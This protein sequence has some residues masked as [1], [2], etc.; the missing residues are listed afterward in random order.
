MPRRAARPPCPERTATIAP[1]APRFL[2][3]LPLWTVVAPVLAGLALLLGKPASPALA[4]LDA[5]LLGAAVLAA[6]H[7]A[8]TVAHAVGEPFGSLVLALAVT[9]IETSLIVSI[10]LTEGAA[11]APLARDTLFATVMIVMNG[12]VGLCLLVGGGRHHEQG[13]TRSGV[14]AGLAMLSTLAVLVLVLPNYTVTRAGPVYAPTQLV[15]VGVVSLVIYASFVFAQTVRHRDHFRHAETAPE[16][17]HAVGTATAWASFGFMVLGLG[18]VVLLAKSLSP[19][20]K[21][22]VAAA[23]APQATVGIVIAGVVLLPEA[24]AALAA[25]RRNDLQ[26]S[27]NLAIGSAL[28][29]TGLTVPAVAAVSVLLGLDLVL[30]LS[31]RDTVL[32]ALTL[33]VT[34]LSLGTGRTTAIHGIVHL[35]LFATFLFT[36][37]V[38]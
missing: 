28:A 17:G 26:T 2:P 29:T 12:I 19:V 7:H 35:V 22:A 13:F 6:V 34:T 3:G 23:G 4:A 31:A 8:E 25:A 32:L 10:M 18:A 11:A 1:H 38:P 24:L 37:I 30:G 9:V 20:I 16:A 5:A 15:F 27:L 21:Q 33:F 14:G 36:T